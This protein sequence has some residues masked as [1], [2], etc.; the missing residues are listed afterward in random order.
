MIS[1]LAAIQ[2]VD[3]VVLL[4]VERGFSVRNHGFE[5]RT[6]AGAVPLDTEQHLLDLVSG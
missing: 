4:I 2:E 3:G 5:S 6:G 1:A